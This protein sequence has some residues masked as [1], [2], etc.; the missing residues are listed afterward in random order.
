MEC[1]RNTLEDCR[2][3]DLGFVGDLFTWRNHLHCAKSYIKER[4]DRD[5]ANMEWRSLFALVRVVNG[6]PDI[7]T[8]DQ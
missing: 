8:V 1:F 5:V 2:L 7:Q 4:L 3:Q 6:D